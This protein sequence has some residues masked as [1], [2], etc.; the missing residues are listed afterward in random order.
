VAL[1]LESSQEQALENARQLDACNRQR[2]AI[3]QQTLDQ[4]LERLAGEFHNGRRSIVLA[5]ADWHPGVIGI[6]ASRLVER[7]HRPTV[8][9]ALEN[10][11]GKGSARSIRGFH[12]YQALHDCQQHLSAYGGH[13]FAAG[14][15]IEAGD[16]ETFAEAFEEV[17]T[18]ELSDEDLQPRHLFDQEVLLEELTLPLVEELEQLA[19]FGAGNPQPLLV[20]RNLRAQGVQVLGEKHL[21]FTARQGGYSHP[22]IAFGMAERIDE[23]SGEFDLL[24]TP[25]INEWRERRSLQLKVK[26]FATVA[27]SK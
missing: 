10:G 20:A 24:F 8:L 15:S 19:P 14:L 27:P 1:L 2:Q 18:R 25:S 17:A 5:D 7:F 21:R 16:I 4:A 9:I 12:L 13:E 22:C 23:L 26:D 11:Q 6:V 3:E